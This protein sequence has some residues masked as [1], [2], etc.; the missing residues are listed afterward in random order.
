MT[1]KHK[2]NE[3]NLMVCLLVAGLIGGITQSLLVFVF[4]FFV[5]AAAAPYSGDIRK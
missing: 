3:A 4:A 2:L 5:L 1:A